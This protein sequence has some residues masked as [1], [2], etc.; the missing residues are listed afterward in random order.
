M[1]HFQHTLTMAAPP[2]AVY[3][4]LSTIDGLRQW[5]SRD[6]DGESELGGTIR[7]RFGICHNAMRVD[8]LVPGHEVGWHCTD[9]HTVGDSVTQSAEWVGTA[10]QFHLSAAEAGGT[11]V[12]FEHVGLT[13]ALECHA[14]CVKGWT[15]FLGSL[16][17]Y[18]ETGE[19]TPYIGA[20]V[21]T[22][23]SLE[24]SAAA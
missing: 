14:M 22:T 23:P 2:A 10:P 15:H 6:C 1:K 17:Q 4:A 8:R 5:W 11:R 13:P 3:A 16:Q 21:P 18:L 20:T 9:A 19:G 7:F 24:R 12:V